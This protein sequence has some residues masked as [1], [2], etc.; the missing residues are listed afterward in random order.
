[1]ALLLGGL[2]TPPVM[3]SVT[4]PPAYV[5]AAEAYRIPPEVLFAVALAESEILL[6]SR[7]VL[8]WPWTLNVEGREERYRTRIEAYEAIQAHLAAGRR[9]IDIGLM[10]VNWHWHGELLQDP[11]LALDPHFNLRAG[12]RILRD[13]HLED[14]DWLISVGRYHAPARTPA[15]QAR[16]ERYRQRV[17]ERL[18]SLWP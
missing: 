1:M 18:E 3:A 14:G 12:A 15:A 2:A 16:A 8:P 13:L 6:T 17:I 7:R 5:A 11:W 10:Q 4:I 9:S